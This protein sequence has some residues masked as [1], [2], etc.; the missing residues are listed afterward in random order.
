L[1]S[2]WTAPRNP[3]RFLDVEDRQRT[4]NLERFCQLLRAEPGLDLARRTRRLRLGGGLPLL[5]FSEAPERGDIEF[6]FRHLHR[7]I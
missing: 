6:E 4:E 3:A 1:A 2:P 5:E 7:R